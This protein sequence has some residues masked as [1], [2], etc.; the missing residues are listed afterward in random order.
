M[1]SRIAAWEDLE[2][3]KQLRT[4]AERSGNKYDDQAA[5]QRWVTKMA[6]LRKEFPDEALE[7]Q[8]LGS[9]RRRPIRRVDGYYNTHYRLYTQY[10]HGVFRATGDLLDDLTNPEDNRTMAMCAFGGLNVLASGD[11]CAKSPGA[12]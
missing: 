8:P 2:D 5:A 7:E 3:Q 12:F 10:A 1:L 4:I 11:R 9:R 6:N